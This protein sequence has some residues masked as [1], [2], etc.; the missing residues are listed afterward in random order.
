MY[1]PIV[2]KDMM[3]KNYS[4][5]AELRADIRWFAHNLK[6]KELNVK[7]KPTTKDFIAKLA[8][9]LVQF[10]DQEIKS[11]L[12]CQEC[13]EKAYK[14]PDN[15]FVMPCQKPHILL[16]ADCED[17]GF[18]PAKLLKYNEEDMTYV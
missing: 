7:T 9:K 13:Y 1:N 2:L 6:T 15:S 14:Y 5:F 12:L 10:C 11:L 18:W 8:Q 16:W 17:Y 4:S 3:K